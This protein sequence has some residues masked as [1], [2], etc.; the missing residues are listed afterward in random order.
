[1]DMAAAYKQHQQIKALHQDKGRGWC[2]NP[3]EPGS[4]Q[5]GLSSV[6]CR[7]CFIFVRMMYVLDLLGVHFLAGAEPVRSGALVVYAVLAVTLPL[8]VALIKE[9]GYKHC[10][11]FDDHHCA[12]CGHSGTGRGDL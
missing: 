9:I 6:P 3:G 7:V 12:D 11:T 10:R 5:T 1:M 8:A 4:L 2:G